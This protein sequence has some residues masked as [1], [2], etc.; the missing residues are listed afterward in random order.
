M[1]NRD[2]H[3]R[4]G[5]IRKLPSGRLQIRYPGP[6]GR[7]R[8]GQETYGRTSDAQKAL[9]LIEAQM[10]IG[11]WT[12]PDRGK[13][14][15]ADYAATW[16]AQR[17]NLR[18]RTVDLYRWLL[19]KHIAPHLG[20]VP[21]GK[22]STA[23]IREWRT[24]LLGNGVSVSMAAKA[25]RL[26][27]AVL[28]TATEEDKILPV[29]PCRIRG[30]GDE[31]AAERPVLTVAQVFALSERVGRRPVG[32][33]RAL[34]G[35]GYRLRFRRFGEMRPRCGALILT[36]RPE[37]CGCALPSWSD[38]PEKSCSGRLSPKPGGASSVSRKLSS[39]CCAS[40]C[41]SSSRTGRVR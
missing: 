28:M 20:G 17:P 1:A 16:I 19:K 40:I 12:D 27:R 29:N 39:R 5:N 41:R 4:F 30:A 11:E 36:C 35:G 32:N 38:R 33:I 25:Y 3:R 23:M 22:L 2:G 31:E 15:L 8:T 13:I 9:V 18:P 21:I 7:M 6:D 14:K 24:E 34:P 37:P 26:L 10:S